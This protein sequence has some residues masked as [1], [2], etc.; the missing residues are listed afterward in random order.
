MIPDPRAAHSGELA[1]SDSALGIWSWEVETEPGD[2]NGV[3]AERSPRAR[4]M[5]MMAVFKLSPGGAEEAGGR[6]RRPEQRELL[7]RDT[8]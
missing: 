3:T 4:Q 2:G 5:I 8:K 6:D 1:Q 7:L